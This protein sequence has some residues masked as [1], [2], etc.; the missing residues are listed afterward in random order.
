VQGNAPA[1]SLLQQVEEAVRRGLA[2][3]C[4]VIIAQAIADTVIN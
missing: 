2:D 4:L 1:V 3:D